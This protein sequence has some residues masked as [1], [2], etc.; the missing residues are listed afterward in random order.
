M[1]IRWD[2]GG[3]SAQVEI[4]VL[5]DGAKHDVAQIGPDS[6]ILRQPLEFAKGP[7]QI[8]VSVDGRQETHEVILYRPDESNGSSPSRTDELAYA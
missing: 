6:L 1:G 7:A 3:Y 4:Y 2:E 5:I 8:V